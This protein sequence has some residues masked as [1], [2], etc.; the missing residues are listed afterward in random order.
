MGVDDMRGHHNLKKNSE[1]EY[2]IEPSVPSPRTFC[3][4]FTHWQ[5][6]AV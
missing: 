1:V 6:P 3:S 4:K 5:L 2:L